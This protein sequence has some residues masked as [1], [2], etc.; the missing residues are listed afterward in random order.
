MPENGS[1][2][3]LYMESAEELNA[4]IAIYR[5]ENHDFDQVIEKVIELLIERDGDLRVS[6]SLTRLMIYYMYYHCD[7]GEEDVA[8]AE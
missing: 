7:I 4:K 1:L 6:K 8:V 5:K 3:M 2:Q